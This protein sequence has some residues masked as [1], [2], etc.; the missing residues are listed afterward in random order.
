LGSEAVLGGSRSYYKFGSAVTQIGDGQYREARRAAFY[1]DPNF[2]RQ[3]FIEN[4]VA[5]ADTGHLNIIVTDLFQDDGN[6]NALV[7]GL[8]NKALLNGKAVGIAAIKSEFRGTIYDVGIRKEKY[9]YQGERPF[10]LVTFGAFGDVAR[11]F[12]NLDRAGRSDEVKQEYL[13]FSAH[14]A[15]PVVSFVRLASDPDFSDTVIEPEKFKDRPAV[16]YFRVRGQEE[17]TSVSARFTLSL[18]PYRPLYDPT[19]ITYGV[20]AWRQ[21]ADTLL[22]DE[23]G[24]RALSIS[25]LESSDTTLALHLNL[26]SYSELAQDRYFFE[27]DVRPSSDAYR[28]PEWVEKWNLDMSMAEAWRANPS[29]FTGDKTQNLVHFLNDLLHINVEGAKPTLARLY[30]FVDR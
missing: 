3:T 5:D 11:L 16:K 28:L 21:E 7:S 9:N 14:I 1:T 25:V 13:I 6:V 18:R 8:R 26:P 10:Y 19:R 17:E 30:F 20:K 22:A 29:A 4:V 15:Q 12:D 23:K 2:N 24:G 27:L